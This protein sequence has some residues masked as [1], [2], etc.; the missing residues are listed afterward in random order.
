MRGKKT[1]GR[2]KGVPNKTTRDVREAI[3]EFARANVDSM[4]AWLNAVEDP[5]KRMDL[6]LRAVEYHIPKLSRAELTGEGG[7]PVGLVVVP[8]K[9]PLGTDP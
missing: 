4:G 2:T 1:G 6:F 5:A 3:A 9:H 8:A 7:G